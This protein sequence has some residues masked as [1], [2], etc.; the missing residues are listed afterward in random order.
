VVAANPPFH[1]RREAGFQI[2]YQFMHHARRVLRPG[3]R[4]YLV[5]NRF[6]A[7]EDFLRDQFETVREVAGDSR[8]KVLLAVQK[9]DL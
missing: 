7:Y 3:G 8:Y 9:G 2:A 1:A 5:A 6:L 4:L